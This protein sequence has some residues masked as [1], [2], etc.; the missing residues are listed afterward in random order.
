MASGEVKPQSAMMPRTF[1][2]KSKHDASSTLVAPIDTP[3][4]TPGG[5]LELKPKNAKPGETV[6]ITVTPD[7]GYELGDLI[8]RDVG[9]ENI[10]LTR[11][12]DGEFSFVM[13]KSSVRISVSFVR[14]GDD[15]WFV[16][17]PGG[18]YYYDAVKWAVEQGVTNGTDKTHYSPDGFCTR[19][20]IVTFLW[21]AAGRPEPASMSS[22]V[23]V[24]ADAYY[25]KAVAWA[26]E[27]GIARGID[28]THFDPD[29]ICTRAHAV[30]F[31]ARAAEAASGSGKTPFTDVSETAYYAPAVKWAAAG[32]VTAGV[33]A[34][35]FAP[36]RTCTRAQIVTFLYRFYAL[37]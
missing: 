15:G 4:R 33:S 11:E 21:R 37:A 27:L 7:E 1:A 24:P 16:D 25:A 26:A 2:G 8:V 35:R 23:D 3:E 34:T 30:T 5:S 17:V 36:D 28:A 12:D 14:E 6:T 10:P 29:G 19:A 18:A 20:Q 13:P 22:F 32:G 9:G 31:L